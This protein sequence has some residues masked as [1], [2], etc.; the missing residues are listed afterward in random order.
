M[1]RSLSRSDQNHMAHCNNI[2]RNFIQ[3]FHLFE[4]NHF[5]PYTD[6][7]CSWKIV[8]TEQKQKKNVKIQCSRHLCP[9]NIHNFMKIIIMWIISYT[10]SRKKEISKRLMNS[11]RCS[12]CV[13][14][15][16]ARMWALLIFVLL[17]ESIHLRFFYVFFPF[18]LNG[19]GWKQVFQ[20]KSVQL[21]I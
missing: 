11:K 7:R 21:Y 17:H 2:D 4:F 1:K 20:F 10:N 16:Y 5:M 6:Y 14:I 15:L 18:D 13:R 19:F 12:S 3:V 9:D 8:K